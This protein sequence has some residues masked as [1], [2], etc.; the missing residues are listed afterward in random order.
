MHGS[1]DTQNSRR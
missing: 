1:S